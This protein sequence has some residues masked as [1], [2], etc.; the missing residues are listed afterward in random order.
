MKIGAQGVTICVRAS[1]PNLS[2]VQYSPFSGLGRSQVS[3]SS[4]L[5]LSE[6]NTQSCYSEHYGN[7]WIDNEGRQ[8]GS[9]EFHQ[10]LHNGSE[11]SLLSSV[12]LLTFYEQKG[13]C[14]YRKFQGIFKI[15][16]KLSNAQGFNQANILSIQEE[17]IKNFILFK[18]LFLE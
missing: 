17:L 2:Q 13:R 9:Q 18:R 3:F 6:L 14:F 15:F 7:V 10:R 8:L 16:R 11:Q 4:F 5:G 12:V 1:G